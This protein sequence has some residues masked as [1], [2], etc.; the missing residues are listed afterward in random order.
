MS[1]YEEPKKDGFHRESPIRAFTTFHVEGMYAIGKG[2]RPSLQHLI[3]YLNAMEQKEGWRLVQILEALSQHPSMVF[4]RDRPPLYKVTIPPADEISPEFKERIEKFLAQSPHV[5]G[6]PLKL[7]PADPVMPE[8]RAKYSQGRDFGDED[9]SCDDNRSDEQKA[10][11]QADE[12]RSGSRRLSG[13]EDMRSIDQARKFDQTPERIVRVPQALGAPYQDPKDRSAIQNGDL[14]EKMADAI[15][16][17]PVNPRHYKG[18]GCAEIAE[19]LPGNL[20]HAI[21]Y[22]WRAGD[23]PDQPELQEIDKSLW[24]MNRE[25]TFANRW[26]EGWEDDEVDTPLLDGQGKWLD[27]KILR[28]GPT[29][30]AARSNPRNHPFYLFVSD[31][32]AAAQLTAWKATTIYG[33]ALYVIERKPAALINAIRAVEQHRGTLDRIANLAERGRGQEP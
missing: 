26:F 10:Q 20:A 22:V 25:V 7:Y 33:M 28:V 23:K 31:R 12:I 8:V 16:D 24:W 30:K 17:D 4:R 18:T 11:D 9:P 15:K 14:Y 21:T 6:Q 29:K 13:L 5:G 27:W 2:F 19:N 3:P 1:L 32:V